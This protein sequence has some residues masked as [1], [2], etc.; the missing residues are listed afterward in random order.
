MIC[1]LNPN[2]PQPINPDTADICQSCGSQLIARLR[3]RYRPVKIIGRGGF[4][5]TYLATDGD[6]LNT[7]CVIKQ[8]APQHQGT[9]S[10][11]K[12]IQL[13]EQE[14]LRLNEL[15]EHPQIPTLLAYFEHE[16]YLYLVQQ[17]IE[18]RTLYQEVQKNGP[19]PEAAVRTLLTDL[20]PVLQFIHEHGVIHRDITPTNVIRRKLDGK[21]VLIDFGVA[22]QFTEAILYEPGTRIG[23][24]GYAPMEQLRSGQAYPSSD[25]YSLGA[26]CLH[27]ITGTKPEVLYS[28]MEGRWMWHEKLAQ[29]GRSC[30]PELANLLDRLVKD[31]V[32]DRYQ[33]AAEVLSVLRQLPQPENAVPGW[34]SSQ[35]GDDVAKAASLPIGSPR[36]V[37][38][39]VPPTALPQHSGP[40]FS[41][42]QRAVSGPQSGPRASGN[43]VSGPSA[44]GSPAAQTPVSGP[45]SGQ[46]PT[47]AAGVSGPRRSGPVSGIRGSGWQCVREFK[48]HAS[49][50]TSVVFNPKMPTVISG[51]LDDT[52]K[53]W[54]LQSGQLIGTLGGH[55]R[56]VNELAIGT[57]GQVLAS[58][59]DD[60]L[61]RV[62]NLAEGSLLHTLKGHMRDVNSVNI[63]VK[64][65][66]LA[67]GSEDMTIKL[68]KL[69]KGTLLKTLT[70]S[71]GMVR[72]VAITNNEEM[73]I[74]G[75][76]DN[77]VRIW[78][79]QTGE[80]VKVLSGHLNTVNQVAVS[81]DNRLL[82]S[83]SKDRTVR[84]WSLT[85]GSLIH[86]LHGHTQEI[87]GV[88]IAPDNRLLVSSSN[89]ATL[90]LWDSQ[91]GEL[92][93]TLSGHTNSVL[94]VAIHPNG[95]LIAS[96]SA[97]KTIRIWRWA[98]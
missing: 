61:I 23:T 1:C 5:R 82:A 55:P 63:G 20:L 58:C 97:D 24:E 74:S 40:Q 88:A 85:S 60:D 30:H 35:S 72:S 68:W 80:Q 94:A 59:G 31:M 56:G 38:P 36:A 57:G 89:D 14:A 2:C 25:L 8:F 16:Q 9:Q 7:Y 27:L 18:G 73:L 62:W 51:S 53:I 41:Q 49:W 78:N 91:N 54:N 19:Y 81:S 26:T 6:R 11:D 32:S 12:A 21:P 75:G 10:L 66:L 37:V 83:A 98:S 3:G 95:R 86:T 84:L 52:I 79:L 17:M 65:F 43:Q 76:L 64:G 44:I 4:G 22:K 46:P 77:K 93:H 42:P 87:N 96:S 13:F 28:P 92:K 69:D 33:S 67:S 34:V 50:V 45:S 15:G 39:T 70:G 29:I 48:G 47:S 71:A 90:K